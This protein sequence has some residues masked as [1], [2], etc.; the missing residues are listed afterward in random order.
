MTGHSIR[1]C[2]LAAVTAI[3][4]G[5]FAVAGAD[6]TWSMLEGRWTGMGTLR[7]DGGGTERLKCVVV[8]RAEG[9]G[10]VAQHLT[11]V[12]SQYRIDGG[13]DLIFEGK[14]VSGTWAE[15][16][17][18][19]GG[20]LA[21]SASNGRMQLNLDGPTFSGTARIETER[22]RQTITVELTNTIFDAI[23]AG[24]RRC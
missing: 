11:C 12:G 13:A 2:V 21:G 15:R 24:F 10:H 3:G 19:V 1:I 7:L 20:G 6:E 14:R 22:C 9:E 8:Y 16:S 23:S 4:S 17:Y 5:W 18:A